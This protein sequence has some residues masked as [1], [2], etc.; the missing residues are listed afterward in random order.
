MF[1]IFLVRSVAFA[2]VIWLG[3]PRVDIVQWYFAL[4]CALLLSLFRRLNVFNLVN[5]RGAS[6]AAA[7][8]RLLVVFPTQFECLRRYL[9]CGIPGMNWQWLSVIGI[10]G[11]PSIMGCAAFLV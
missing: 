8:W 9:L 3:T 4:V 7:F 6:T 11:V 5:Q 10:P 2:A 1:S